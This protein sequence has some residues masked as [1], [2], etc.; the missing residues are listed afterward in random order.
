MN[1][2]NVKLQ[3]MRNNALSKI[4][5]REDKAKSKDKF[6]RKRMEP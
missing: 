2:W 4:Y 3:R 6:D 1:V 5:G